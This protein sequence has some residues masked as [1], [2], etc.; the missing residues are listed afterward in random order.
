M[1]TGEDFDIFHKYVE[2]IM[3]RP[4]WTHEMCHIAE[5]IKNRARGEFLRLCRDAVDDEKHGTW[6]DHVTDYW[7]SECG[8]RIQKEQAKMF[9][10]CPY[11]GA[12]ME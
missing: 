5:E 10:I 3:G 4:V 8:G 9:S 11:C 7:C 6:V 2:D 1:L 12:R